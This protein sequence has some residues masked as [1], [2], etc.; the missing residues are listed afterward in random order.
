MDRRHF[1]RIGSFSTVATAVIPALQA[2]AKQD[3]PSAPL[4]H[5]HVNPIPPSQNRAI[6]SRHVIG[7]SLEHADQ[8]LVKG[9]SDDV[10]MRLV[11]AFRAEWPTRSLRVIMVDRIGEAAAEGIIRDRWA[12]SVKMSASF[13]T[14]YPPYFDLARFRIVTDHWTRGPQIESYYHNSDPSGFRPTHIKSMFGEVY[15]A[16]VA[17]VG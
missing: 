14:N 9:L 1:I 8:R 16:D 7:Q 17:V 13:A 4:I 5:H 10:F 6:S 3:P 2:H 15:G 11:S 12:T